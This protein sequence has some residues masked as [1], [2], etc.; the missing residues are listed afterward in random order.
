M[1]FLYVH[2]TELHDNK[3]FIILGIPVVMSHFLVSNVFTYLNILR[4]VYLLDRIV[5]QY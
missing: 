3:S 5:S 2:V 4:S 1:K